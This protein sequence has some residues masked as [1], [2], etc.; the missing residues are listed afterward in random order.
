MEASTS[1]GQ[2]G[3]FSARRCF[4]VVFGLTFASA[5]LSLAVQ[6]RGLFGERGISPAGEF[7]KAVHSQLGT[8]AFWEVPTLC[9][10]DAGDGM[11]VALSI[12]GALLSLGIALGFAPGA[13]SLA[14]WAIYLSLC[15]VGSPFL[16]F[17]G[18]ALLL[19]TAL[20]AAFWLPWRMR[21]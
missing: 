21:P 19:E 1:P 18:D 4:A 11:L 8:Q 16:N 12:A 6:V 10:M 5:F 9:W 7:L 17:Q 14:C 15:S 13:C 2:M 3:F 20:L